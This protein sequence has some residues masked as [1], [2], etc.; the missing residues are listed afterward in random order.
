MSNFEQSAGNLNQRINKNFLVGASETKRNSLNNI[1]VS[2]S[3]WNKNSLIYERACYVTP[4]NKFNLKTF[5]RTYSTSTP[6]LSLNKD[7]VE[8]LPFG[9]RRVKTKG[10]RQQRVE[11]EDN[12]NDLTPLIAYCNFKEDKINILKAKFSNF[13]KIKG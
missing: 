1:K 3:P 8:F 9:D 12:T 6:A 4:N 10:L 7:V 13:N 11:I 2:Y 5:I